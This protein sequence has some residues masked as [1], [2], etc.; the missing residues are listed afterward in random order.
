MRASPGRAGLTSPSLMDRYGVMTS[1]NGSLDLLRRALVAGTAFRVDR[2]YDGSGIAVGLGVTVACKKETTA[3]RD[4]SATWSTA[5]PSRLAPPLWSTEPRRSTDGGR[6][7]LTL[8]GSLMAGGASSRA[9]T[10]GCMPTRL[11][12][13]RGYCAHAQSPKRRCQSRWSTN[14]RT[15]WLRRET[16]C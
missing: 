5:R 16:E 3:G 14:N 7:G 10:S 6:V 13:C 9:R 15:V 2:M 1:P 12:T 8:D 4:G 11:A